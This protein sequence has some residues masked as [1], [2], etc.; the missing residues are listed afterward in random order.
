MQGVAQTEVFVD[1][2][3]APCG[4]G[5]AVGFLPGIVAFCRFHCRCPGVEPDEFPVE[6][7]LVFECLAAFEGGVFQRLLCLCRQCRGDGDGDGEYDACHH[8]NSVLWWVVIYSKK[9]APYYFLR[10]QR[11]NG[12]TCVLRNICRCLCCRSKKKTCAL[13]FFTTTETTMTTFCLLQALCCLL[14]TTKTTFTSLK[15]GYH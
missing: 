4:E 15:A 8:E 9:L 14:T 3:T 13:L 10:Q 2:R 7:H 1:F 6:I 5:A 11:H 12:N